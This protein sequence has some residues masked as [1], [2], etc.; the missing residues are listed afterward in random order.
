[1]QKYKHIQ[2]EEEPD[3]HVICRSKHSNMVLGSLERSILWVDFEYVPAPN[4]AY[5]AESL[6]DIADFMEKYNAELK[7]KEKENEQNA[8]KMF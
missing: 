8:S 4:T 3:G 5:I 6:R 1:M 7:A 2:F